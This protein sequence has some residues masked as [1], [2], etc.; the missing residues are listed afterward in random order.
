MAATQTVV[1][2]RVRPQIRDGLF[3]AEFEKVAGPD[4]VLNAGNDLNFENCG[5]VIMKMTLVNDDPAHSWA[6][7]DRAPIIWAIAYSDETD[8]GLLGFI[9]PNDPHD[10]FDEP[11][12]DGAE[13][14]FQYR[15]KDRF[16]RSRYALFLND[17][18]DPNRIYVID[19]IIS[20][21]GNHDH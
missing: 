3:D 16:K 10:Q 7:V 19:P 6:W 9:D 15:N 4:W 11:K 5:R 20:N 2:L 8:E 1:E 17:G 12:I 21:G 14:S 13:L 18:P